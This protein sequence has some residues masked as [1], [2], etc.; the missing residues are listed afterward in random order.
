[1]TQKKE[2]RSQVENAYQHISIDSEKKQL[3]LDNLLLAAK[4]YSDME[5]KS[6]TNRIS[7]IKKTKGSEK[8]NRRIAVAAVTVLMLGAGGT[9]VAAANHYLSAQ[10]VAVNMEDSK[11]AEA[12]EAKE[13]AESAVSVVEEQAYR[14][15]YL[16]TIS[17]AN[18]E[19]TFG[20]EVSTEKTYFVIAVEKKDG[21]EMTYEEGLVVSPLIQGL[22]PIEYNIFTFGNGAAQ[23]KIMD[24][25][26][27]SIV[28]VDSIEMFADRQLYL[29]VTQGVTYKEAYQFDRS[30]GL[31]AQDSNFSG[32]NALFE[33]ELDKSKADVTL[34]TDFINRVDA[35]REAVME[36]D[37]PFDGD[38]GRAPMRDFCVFE[39]NNKLIEFAANVNWS[40]VA[41]EDIEKVIAMGTLTENRIFPM[42]NGGFQIDVENEYGG[43]HGFSAAELYEEGRSYFE[44]FSSCDE[45]EEVDVMFSYELVKD[46]KLTYKQIHYDKEQLQQMYDYFHE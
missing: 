10:D 17:G 29:A 45:E 21:S 34:Q 7:K 13:F 3:I 12:F 39:S 41:V 26:Y 28:S 27:Y 31:I 4:E 16:G 14:M 30:T 44:L 6:M 36:T 38:A 11:L 23:C 9:G 46:G 40:C 43:A 2:M 35:N 18:L 1:M 15:A 42:E 24:G 32:V 5:R 25:K 33:M 8:Y 19:E 37:N 22:D 20:E